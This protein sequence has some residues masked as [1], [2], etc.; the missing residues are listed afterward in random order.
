DGLESIAEGLDGWQQLCDPCRFLRF[1]AIDIVKAEQNIVVDRS[2]KKKDIL[3]DQADGGLHFGNRYALDIDI[4]DKNR[5]IGWLEK[6][7]QQTDQ[8]ALAGT[9]F[10]H[11]TADSTGRDHEINALQ[12]RGL[13]GRIRES[14]ITEFDGASGQSRR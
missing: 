2:G 8:G 12:H 11:D 9:C 3:R 7:E 4:I 14:E 5:S 1:L 13:T 10:S 6:P